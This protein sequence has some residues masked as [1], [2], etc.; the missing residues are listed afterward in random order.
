MEPKPRL[1]FLVQVQAVVPD[2]PRCDEPQQLVVVQ[3]ERPR[4]LLGGRYQ[5]DSLDAVPVVQVVQ[6][7]PLVGLPQGLLPVPVA[8]RVARSRLLL[9]GGGDL[10]ARRLS[11]SLS[12]CRCLG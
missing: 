7:E 8:S 5:V 10:S 3:Q 1:E 6:E 2:L 11:L 9:P 4:R 12:M